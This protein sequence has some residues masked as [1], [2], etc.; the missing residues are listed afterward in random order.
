MIQKHKIPKLCKLTYIVVKEG[1]VESHDTKGGLLVCVYKIDKY[2]DI[3]D[4]MGVTLALLS[5]LKYSP[6][7]IIL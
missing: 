4:T 5:N 1:K 3:I 2:V 6:S 7:K